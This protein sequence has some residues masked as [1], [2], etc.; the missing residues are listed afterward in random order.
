ME[1][2]GA[3]AA[4]AVLFGAFDQDAAQNICV[5]LSGGNVDPDMAERADQM[6]I[7]KAR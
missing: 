3:V 5:I 2:G 7:K 1:P 4:A 6:L